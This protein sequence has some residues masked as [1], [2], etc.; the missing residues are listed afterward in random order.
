MSTERSSGGWSRPNA[1]RVSLAVIM[2]SA[3]GSTLDRIIGLEVGA[4]VIAKKF[5]DLVV[6][7]DNKHLPGRED[8]IFFHHF[9]FL[10]VKHN[11]EL[12][13]LMIIRSSC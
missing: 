13:A 12:C 8:H 4:D 2:L 11:M 6:I 10:K 1:L 9:N 3:K 7:V 5:A